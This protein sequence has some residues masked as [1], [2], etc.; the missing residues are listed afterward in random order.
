VSAPP[1]FPEVFAELTA[2]G[3]IPP[4]SVRR[5][6][7]AILAGQW[8]PVQVAGFAVALRLCGESAELISAAAESLRAAM[9]PVEHGLPLVLDTC[10]TGGDGQG[11]L[12]LSTGAALI[13]AAAGVPV[14][15]HGNRAVSSRA[16]SADVLEALGIPLDVP[17][18][19]AAALVRECGIAFLMAPAHHPAMRHGGVARR[20][21]G[22]RTIFNCLGPLANPARASH[23]LLGAYSDQL[24]PVLAKTLGA[25]GVQAAWVVRGADGLD[26]LSPYAETRVTVLANGVLDELVVAPEDFGLARLSPGAASGGDAEENARAL[27][28]VLSGEPHPAR[29]AFVLNAAAALVVARG[30]EPKPAAQ[31]ARGAIDSGAALRTLESWRKL[32]LERRLGEPTA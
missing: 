2:P 32:A 24:R 1:R 21:L 4:S 6:F 11:T 14:A 25:L 8:T 19:A 16:G 9:V 13:A 7:D 10:G 22:I 23:Q 30:L 29:D 18:A 3:G 28:A 31:I 15:K 17:P 26:E 20:E 12:N 27:R 5:V